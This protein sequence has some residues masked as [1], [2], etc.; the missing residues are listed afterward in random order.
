MT[1]TYSFG[2]N[3][4]YGIEL[5]LFRADVL[6]F[7]ILSFEWVSLKIVIK[8]FGLYVHLVGLDISKDRVCVG[9]MNCYLAVYYG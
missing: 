8:L 3:Q 7:E 1:F 4:I 9:L 6:D 2:K 5:S